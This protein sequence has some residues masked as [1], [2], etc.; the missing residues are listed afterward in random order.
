MVHLCSGYDNIAFG[1]DMLSPAGNHRTDPFAAQDM[2]DTWRCAY[3]DRENHGDRL[4]CAG[5]QA[6]RPREVED[7]GLE[8]EAIRDRW[9]ALYG[10]W[11]RCDEVAILESG[12]HYAPAI[13]QGPQ[14]R[15]PIHP[16]DTFGAARSGGI[17]QRLRKMA[18]IR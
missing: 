13:E 17:L 4:T 15:P 11:H 10:G 12:A 6:G 9:E 3:C 1:Y 2:P 8:A 18:G 14:P 7:G 5:C 16:A